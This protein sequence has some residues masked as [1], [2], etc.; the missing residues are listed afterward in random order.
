MRDKNNF[1]MFQTTIFSPAWV[2]ASPSK[3]KPHT[4]TEGQGLTEQL[5]LAF[6]PP[7]TPQVDLDRLKYI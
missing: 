5:I 2:S 4:G 1:A 7:T 3:Y 6:L